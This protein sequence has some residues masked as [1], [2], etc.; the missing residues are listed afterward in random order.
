MMQYRQ[1]DFIAAQ[2][3]P[4]ELVLAGPGRR[5]TGA[6]IDYALTLP[7]LTA[8]TL[9]FFASLAAGITG[10]PSAV[11]VAG[12]FWLFG[13]AAFVVWL[14]WAIYAATNGQSPG[15]QILSMYVIKADGTRAGFGYMLLRELLVKQFLTFFLFWL[16]FGIYWLI[17]ALWCAWDRDNQCLW[18]KISSTYV[19]WS[20]HGFKPLTAGERLFRGTPLPASRSAES[21]RRVAPRPPGNSGSR[22]SVLDAGR[23]VGDIHVRPG[24]VMMVGRADDAGIRLSD[25][26]VSRRHLEIEVGA[27]SWII[28]D[29]GAT[30][31]AEVIAGGPPRQ[32]RGTETLAAGQIGVGDSVLTLYPLEP[33]R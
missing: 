1:A 29:L 26:R 15:K 2:F 28:R 9:S 18:D 6:M 7:F 12:Y 11:A 32:I 27:A 4:E 8:L 19:A 16:T 20:P 13:Q 5:L 33:L 24:Q 31:P 22:V 23:N 17:A 3:R 25:P 14:V 21:V 30:N 10:D